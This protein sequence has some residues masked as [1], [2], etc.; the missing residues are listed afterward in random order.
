[1]EARM[2]VGSR[3]T[4]R[5]RGFTYVLV[6][7]LIALLGACLAA[8]GPRWSDDALRDR[9]QELLRVGALYAAAIGSYHASSPGSAKRYPP[10]LEALLLD[11]RFV[12][13]QRHLRRLVPDPLA[14]GRPWGLVRAADGGIQGVFSQDERT[15]F[16]SNPVDLGA[17]SI[18]AGKRYA[19]WVFTPKEQR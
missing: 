12:G 1:M 3:N 5:Q 11:T 18:P 6:M 17:A 19:D 2:R 10:T 15:P 8:I 13:T 4:G 7:A 9:E 14:P 16:L